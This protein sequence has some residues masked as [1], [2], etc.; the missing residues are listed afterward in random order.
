MGRV[1]RPEALCGSPRS[2]SQ[3]HWVP[4]EPKVIETKAPHS[5]SAL[6]KCPDGERF[7]TLGGSSDSELES[8]GPEI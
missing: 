6:E 2:N 1:D 8:V 5:L 3:Q 4:F 7:P